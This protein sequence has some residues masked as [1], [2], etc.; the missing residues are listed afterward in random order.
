M[1]ANRARLSEWAIGAVS[2]VA[3]LLL[4][5]PWG[6]LMPPAVVMALGVAVAVLVIG[7]AMFWWREQP[8]DERESLYAL[9]AGRVSYLAGGAVLLAGVVYQAFMHHI[10]PWLPLALGAMILTKLVVSAWWQQK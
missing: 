2:A 7:F 8:R 10:D 5:D 6:M 9:R 3:L 1:K 4:V